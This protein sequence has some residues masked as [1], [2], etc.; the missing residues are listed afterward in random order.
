VKT[1]PLG[2]SSGYYVAAATT[3]SLTNG[4]SAGWLSL[5]IVI[6]ALLLMSL[7]LLAQVLTWANIYRS[8]LNIETAWKLSAGLVGGAV[9]GVGHAVEAVIVVQ[10]R[11]F[12]TARRWSV[13][14]RS[15]L[16][17]ASSWSLFWSLLRIITFLSVLARTVTWILRGDWSAD[18]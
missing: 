6:S 12:G 8:K 15:Q 17:S 14:A 18:E 3:A 7:V 13:G 4:A 9:Q 10:L 2:V 5:V 11:S 1:N 16:I